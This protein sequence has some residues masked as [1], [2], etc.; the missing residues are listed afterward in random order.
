LELFDEA[1]VDP[2]KLR[3]IIVT[4]AHPDHMGHLPALQD[5]S[6]APVLLHPREVEAH[7]VRSENG[8]SWRKAMGGWFRQHGAPDDIVVKMVNYIPKFQIIP[9]G[10]IRPLMDGEVISVG[11]MRWEIV[12]TPGH[13]PGHICLFERQR[14]LIITGDHVLPHDTPNV[15]ALP[16][17][18]KNPLGSFIDSLRHVAGLK[19]R[20]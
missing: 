14:G 1:G 2:G 7:A 13:S 20:L 15:Q 3:G 6:G 11:S 17:L 10:V 8:D 18:P 5:L 12:W 16:F 19:V 9:L 4:H